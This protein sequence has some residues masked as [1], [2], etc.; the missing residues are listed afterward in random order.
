MKTLPVALSLAL[1]FGLAADPA[2]A[3]K[4]DKDKITENEQPSNPDAANDAAGIMKRALPFKEVQTLK[5]FSGDGKFEGTAVRRHHTIRF[6]DP[7]G[8]LIGKAERVTQRQTNY[9]AADGTFIGR[10]MQQKMTMA[11]TATT[12]EG[13]GFINLYERKQNEDK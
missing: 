5:Y 1:A 8:A 4:R 2:L 10:R 7:E 13:K 12:A 11:N 6:Y 9:Y 3:Q